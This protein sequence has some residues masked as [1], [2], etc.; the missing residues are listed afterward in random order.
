VT[1]SFT[2]TTVLALLASTM[3]AVADCRDIP[4][5]ADQADG[6]WL[7]LTTQGWRTVD[8]LKSVVADGNA[9]TVSFAYIANERSSDGSRRGIVVVKSGL[10]GAAATQ[11]GSDPVT[12]ERQGAFVRRLS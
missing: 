3:T 7:F 6:T 5:A 11:G 1:R 2:A 12:L 4:D 9:R 10:A 8:R